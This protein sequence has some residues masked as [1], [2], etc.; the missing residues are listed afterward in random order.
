[1]RP[2]T[3]W[4]TTSAKNLLPTFSS[5]VAKLLLQLHLTIDL[6]FTT[7]EPCFTVTLGHAKSLPV[8]MLR[9]SLPC[10]SYVYYWA[11]IIMIFFLFLSDNRNS[12]SVGPEKQQINLE[13]PY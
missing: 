13:W 12:G 4:M 3:T 10:A 6:P 5:R 2:N 11:K 8:A 1:M 7:V 9:N